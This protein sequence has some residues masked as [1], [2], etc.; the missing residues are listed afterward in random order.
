MKKNFVFW[1]KKDAD[2]V[3]DNFSMKPEYHAYF[4]RCNKK[5][6]FRIAKGKESYSGKGFFLEVFIYDGE[7][8]VP[9]EKKFKAD[10]IYQYATVADNTFDNAVPLLDSIEFKSWCPDKW[11]QY[12]LLKEVMPF[13]CLITKETDY[14]ESLKKIKTEKAVLKP[15]RG[16]KGENVA[17]FYKNNPPRLNE[18][19]LK[20]KGYLLQEFA[21][22]NIKIPNLV[23]GLHDIK[24]ITIGE[25]VFGNL[26]V[27]ENGKE[28]C[29]YDSPY[30]ELDLDDLPKEVLDLHKKVK[31][32]VSERFP[33]QIYTVDVG[34]TK[35][36][37][38]VFELNGHTAFPYLHFNYADEFFKSMIKQ[39][40]SLK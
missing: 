12:E 24:L 28:Y 36:G 22:T 25:K 29:T 37:P 7:K 39:V 34:M 26:R 20:S 21:D 5:F 13:T 2:P 16:Q 15:R 14:Q 8:I 9:A 23:S 38:L 18:A 31:K 1:Q 30:T 27:P 3:I 4:R 6:N 17:V 19:I 40:D 11:N 32:L 10:V 33:Q 35:D